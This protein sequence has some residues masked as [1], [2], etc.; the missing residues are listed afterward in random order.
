MSDADAIL[1]CLKRGNTT[2]GP[3]PTEDVFG[4]QRIQ[5]DAPYNP[6]PPG[7]ETTFRESHHRGEGLYKLTELVANTG[8]SVWIWSGSGQIFCTNNSRTPIPSEVE[9]AG[10]A[11]AIELPVA[12]FEN[13]GVATN[14]DEYDLLARRLKL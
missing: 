5:L 2:A 7:V 6:Y 4:P 12:A 11:I 10:T 13:S 8:G 9:W 3:A 14:R 1:W